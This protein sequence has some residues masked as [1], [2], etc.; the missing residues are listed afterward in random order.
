MFSYSYA[1]SEMVKREYKVYLERKDYEQ[2]NYYAKLYS[3]GKKTNISKFLKLIAQR[4]CTLTLTPS[5]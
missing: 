1:L 5:V 2:L 3:Q 4:G